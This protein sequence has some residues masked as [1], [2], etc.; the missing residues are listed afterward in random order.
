MDSLNQLFAIAAA[1]RIAAGKLKSEAIVAA[2]LERISQR[3]KDVQACAFVDPERGNALLVAFLRGDFAREFRDQSWRCPSCGEG[4]EGQF[5]AC[6][7]CGA[8]RPA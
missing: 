3:E 8:R 6:W 2:C 4:L 7:K 5:T 1:A